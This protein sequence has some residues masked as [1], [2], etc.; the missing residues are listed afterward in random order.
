[1]NNHAGSVSTLDAQVNQTA[2]V[3]EC[4]LDGS[5]G[6]GPDGYGSRVTIATDPTLFAYTVSYAFP[7]GTGG[8]DAGYTRKRTYYGPGPVVAPS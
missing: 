3:F 7:T 5:T 4:T 8:L 2:L 1:L 6:C